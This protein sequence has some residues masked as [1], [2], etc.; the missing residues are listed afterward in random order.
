MKKFIL[1]F[2]FFIPFISYGQN[3]SQLESFE[4]IKGSYSLVENGTKVR[5]SK[6][7]E[8]LG[9]SRETLKEGLV[10]FFKFRKENVLILQYRMLIVLTLLLLQ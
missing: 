8:N 4:K 9:K 3:S 10:N 1:S 5:Y 2:L 6:I 7:Y